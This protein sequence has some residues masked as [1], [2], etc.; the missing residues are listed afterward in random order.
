MC[1]NLYCFMEV[2][3]SNLNQ[4]QL[5]RFL[6]YKHRLFTNS[7]GPRSL[8]Y[9][10]INSGRN[11]DFQCL[12]IKKY[13][14]KFRIFRIYNRIRVNWEHWVYVTAKLSTSFKWNQYFYI[15]F[16]YEFRSKWELF[17]SRLNKLCYRKMSISKKT[18][19]YNICMSFWRKLRSIN[20][21]GHNKRRW[22]D[23]STTQL[24]VATLHVVL[25]V[26][27]MWSSSQWVISTASF[28][29]YFSL[30]SWP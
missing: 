11:K 2:I 29:V 5:T 8:V 13:L 23:N 19:W 22:L 15:F 4:R 24:P 16:T 7:T 1:E 21:G 27:I 30:Y 20:E 6:D 10:N 12:K 14:R 28:H 17:Y 25:K 18:W 26:T 9:H 3:I